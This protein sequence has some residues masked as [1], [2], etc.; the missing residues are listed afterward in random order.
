MYSCIVQAYSPLG[1]SNNPFAKI[2]VLELPLITKLAEKY[3]RT[4]AQIALQWNVNQGHSVLPKST[5]ADRIASNIEFF[6]FEISEEDLREF[7]KIQQVNHKSTHSCEICLL[8]VLVESCP[9]SVNN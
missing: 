7:E 4:P 9:Y 5:H 3:E 1:S 8:T 2:N 6:D